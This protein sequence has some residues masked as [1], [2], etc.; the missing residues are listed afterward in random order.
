MPMPHLLHIEQWWDL[1]GLIWIPKISSKSQQIKTDGYENIHLNV[2][3]GVLYGT[4]I[5]YIT[6]LYMYE[7]NMNF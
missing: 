3:S 7:H 5:L 4:C 1:A 2:N 6:W